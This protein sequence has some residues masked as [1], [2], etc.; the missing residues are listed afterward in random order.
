MSDDL[1][2]ILTEGGFDVVRLDRASERD[3]AIWGCKIGVKPGQKVILPGGSDFPMREA[4]EE[5]F[6]RI[7]GI[8]AEFCFSGWGEELTEGEKSVLEPPHD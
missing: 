2:K 7:T 5:A 8:E 4:V 6:E 3:G 1:E